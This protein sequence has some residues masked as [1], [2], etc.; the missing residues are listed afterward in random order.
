V[1]RR[2]RM[3]R[4]REA[5]VLGRMELTRA[6]LLA[7]N[8]GLGSKERAR[9]SENAMT[10][11]NLSRALT[12]APNITLLGSIVIGSLLIGPRR[13]LP[14]VVRIGVTGW[15]AHQVRAAMAR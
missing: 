15:I 6:Q 4:E 8:K 3:L 1:N 11:S 12:A 7:T 2:L 13:V 5:L 14:T 9:K 10:F